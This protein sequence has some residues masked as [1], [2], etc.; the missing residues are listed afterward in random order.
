MIAL[1]GLVVDAA[2]A[3]PFVLA[4]LLV[5]AING[6]LLLI[7]AAAVAAIALLPS[8]PELPELPGEWGAAVTY[9]LPLSTMVAILTGFIVAWVA[10]WAISAL[11]RWAKVV[12]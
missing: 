2:E 7:G 12:A 11:L 10:W 4:G 8:F 1:L 6:W 3:I 5:D 9:F